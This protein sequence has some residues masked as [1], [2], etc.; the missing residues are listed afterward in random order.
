LE[1]SNLSYF[2][3]NLGG[4]GRRTIRSQA[5]AFHAFFFSGGAF[6]FEATAFAPPRAPELQIAVFSSYMTHPRRGQGVAGEGRW[7]TRRASSEDRSAKVA[8][9]GC[10]QIKW[11]APE[12]LSARPHPR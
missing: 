5:I 4:G 3:V 8:V 12:P 1:R 11:A 2:G 9:D 6:Q 7:R 10:G